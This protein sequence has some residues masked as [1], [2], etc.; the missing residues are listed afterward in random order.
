MGSAVDSAPFL[1]SRLDFTEHIRVLVGPGKQGFTVHKDIISRHSPF[2]RA[3]AAERWASTD[4]H[5]AI[6]LPEDD[7][8]LFATYLHC[9]YH[10]A[11]V[12]GDEG[13]LRYN[14]NE[15]LALYTMADKFRDLKT[16]N[17]VIDQLMARTDELDQVPGPSDI[18]AFY[19]TSA[20]N[21]PLR[22]LM[23]DFYTYEVGPGD[24][25][26]GLGSKLPSAFLTDFFVKYGQL[27]GGD[28][29]RSV[30]ETFE[31]SLRKSMSRCEYHQ[32]DETHLA[33]KDGAAGGKAGSRVGSLGK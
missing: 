33:C 15:Y 26:R 29:S 17:L 21:S 31:K 13:S 3:A 10:G 2:F 7:P 25:T 22:R 12:F 6:E 27:K 11:V 20:E 1:T 18:T 5:K 24:I 16:A 9:V 19:E 32:H 23:V 30:R 14:L 8:A 4:H 28:R